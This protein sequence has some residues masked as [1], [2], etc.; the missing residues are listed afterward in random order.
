MWR[1]WRLI[2]AKNHRLQMPPLSKLLPQPQSHP[3]Q[4]NYL[5]PLSKMLP[6]L[7]QIRF[8]LYCA[9]PHSDS[10]GV[11]LC[12]PSSRCFQLAKLL[13]L[14][15]LQLLGQLR[16]RVLLLWS[17]VA[18]Y[19]SYQYWEGWDRQQKLLPHRICRVWNHCAI[20]GIARL[21]FR[22]FWNHQLLPSWIKQ[23][24][25]WNQTCTEIL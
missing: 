12:D 10:A 3:D 24:V 9:A 18:R 25:D 7:R 2:W 21:T 11:E 5:M 20:F 16:L 17:T 13:V 1:H 6:L 22:L 15:F 4:L 14:G 23:L 19:H 8:R